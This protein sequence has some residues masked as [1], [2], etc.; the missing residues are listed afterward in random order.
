MSLPPS[1]FQ[2]GQKYQA[3]VFGYG[4]EKDFYQLEVAGNYLTAYSESQLIPGETVYLEVIKA[5][6]QPQL[7]IIKQEVKLSEAEKLLRTCRLEKTPQ[8]LKLL[9]QYLAS[10]KPVQFGEILKFIKSHQN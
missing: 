7:R 9:E 1:F 6:N 3:K 10:G 4:E 8:N 5:G 2:T